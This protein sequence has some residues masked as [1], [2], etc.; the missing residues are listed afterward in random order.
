MIRSMTGFGRSMAVENGWRVEASVRTVNHRYLSVRIRALADQPELAARAEAAAK[1]AF[2]RGEIGVWLSIEPDVDGSPRSSFDAVRAT[3]LYEELKELSRLLD[4]P[5]RP[6]LE[7][8][9]R[10]GGLQSPPQSEDDLWPA[11]KAALDSAFS[12]T[13]KSRETEGTLLRDELLRRLAD[14]EDAGRQVEVHLP[15]IADDLRT[16]LRERADDLALELDPNRLETEIALLVERTDVQE[17][18]TR[19]F[20]HI[21]RARALLDQDHPIGKELDFI[22]QELLRE[23]NTLGSKARNSDV[24]H[25]VIDMKLAIEQFREQVQNVE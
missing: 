23:V 13:T 25:T 18:L 11:I 12:L 17:E 10:A 8:L 16:K 14:L 2:S 1:T 9:I 20:G 7:S 6:S 24:N 19:L 4:L 15:S 21:D 22:S 5:D 3:R